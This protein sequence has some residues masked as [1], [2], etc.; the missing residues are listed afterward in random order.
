MDDSLRPLTEA[1]WATLTDEEKVVLTKYTQSY[2]YL[3]EPLRG[4]SYYGGRT[5]NEYDHDMP[6]LTSALNKFKTAKDMVVRR[7]T[8]NFYIPELR[9]DLSGVSVGDTFTDGAF[10][11]TACHRSKGFH[12]DINMII[13]VPKGARGAFAEPFSHY[14]DNLRFYHDGELWDGKSKESINSEFEWIGQ[15]GS[16]FK[17]IKV[18]GRNI[19]LQ[20]IG[21]LR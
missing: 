10:L 14:T 19:Y 16:R 9:K 21:Q 5:Q 8:G 1:V 15:R 18:D 2:S 4:L 6:I 17:V 3:N 11:S 12:D 7:G 20:M 13:L